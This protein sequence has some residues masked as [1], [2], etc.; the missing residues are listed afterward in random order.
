L[1]KGKQ[2]LFT[3][4]CYNAGIK[5]L[6]DQGYLSPLVSAHTR[7]HANT[8][9][10]KKRGGEFVTGDLEQL[11]NQANITEPALDEVESL[12]ADRKSWIVFCVGVDHARDVAQAMRMRGWSTEVVVGDTPKIDREQ[13]LAAFKAGKVRALVSVGVLT[14]GFDAPNADALICLRPTKSPGLWVQMVGRIA[15]LSTGK[16]NGMVVDFTNNTYEHGPIDLITCD[17][18]GDVKTCPYHVCPMCGKLI[19]P[20]AKACACGYSFE[21]E[22]AKCHALFDRDLKQCPDCG[23]WI[24][25]V[26][27][28]I[29]HNTEA[30]DGEILSGEGDNNKFYV[31]DWSFTRHT[32]EGKPDSLKVTYW[33]TMMQSRSEWVCLEH[34]GYAG[35]KASSWWWRRCGKAPTPTTV[36]EALGRT[37]ELKCPTEI[38]IKK[39]GKYW[40]VL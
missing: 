19:E 34:G 40:R 35:E 14:T 13:R 8:S 24:K 9:N 11:M 10:V 3:D 4:I 15:R 33:D 6:I 18:S 17:K 1:I 38:T 7:N 39:E 25:Q 5:D 20:K 36:G 21:R 16:V 32:K 37:G 28:K 22:C 2:R 26:G 29:D 12:C 31:V 30:A 27:R 23:H